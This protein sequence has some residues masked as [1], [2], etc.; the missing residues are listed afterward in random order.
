MAIQ[1]NANGKHITQ[2]TDPYP[3]G[4]VGLFCWVKPDGWTLSGGGGSARTLFD[5]GNR[6]LG[7]YPVS[8]YIGWQ[9]GRQLVNNDA[10]DAIAADTWQPWLEI[11]D[12]ASTS[13]LRIGDL[14]AAGSTFPSTMTTSDTTGQT[15]YIGQYSGGSRT[16]GADIAHYTL[17]D[18]TEALTT[19]ELERLMTMTP[20]LAV[21]DRILVYASLDA[22]TISGSTVT[23]EVGGTATL[24]GSPSVVDGPD[25][26]MPSTGVPQRLSRMRGTRLR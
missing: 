2:G 16:I 3:T 25:I 7:Y 26:V 12:P 19:E 13:N 14:T 6:H 11:L 18:L 17:L 21:P 20:D 23:M 5:Q 4:K 9:G 15:R 22:A 10:R 8:M 24:V 1:L